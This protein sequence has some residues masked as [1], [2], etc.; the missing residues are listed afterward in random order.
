[1][2]TAPHGQAKKQAARRAPASFTYNHVVKHAVPALLAVVAACG[3]KARARDDGGAGSHDA[4]VAATR[5]AAPAPPKPA[6]VEHGVFELV[7]N[8]HAAHRAIDGE[9][10]LD[11]RDIGFARF[12]RFGLPAAHWRLGATVDGERAALADAFAPVE[13]PMSVEQARAT[14]ITVRVYGGVKRQI[15]GVKVNGRAGGKH[16]RVPLEPGW[17]T[18]A[19]PIDPGRFVA[20]ENELAFETTGGG[21]DRVAFAWIRA[22][23]SHPK[24]DEDPLAAAAFDAK[25]DALELASGAELAWYVAVPDGANLVAE[26]APGPCR[27]EVAARAS[28]ATAAGG[29]LG[30]DMRRIDLSA[31]AGRVARLSLAARDCPRARLVHPRITLVG[32]PPQPLPAADP[33]RF[34]VVWVMD[35]LRADKLPAFTAGARATTPN[36]VE[37]AKSSVVFREHYAHGTG[38]PAL[39]ASVA[40]LDRELAAAGYYTTGVTGAGKTPDEP[41]AG[42]VIVDTALAQLDK[43]RDG[44]TYLFVRT[45]DNRPP[46]VARTPWIDTYAPGGHPDARAI[47]DSDVSYADVQLGRVVQRLQSLGAWDQTLLIITSDRGLALDAGD[48]GSLR[49]SVVHVPLLVHD[50]GRF[51]GG[52]V[53]DDGTEQADLVPTILAALGRPAP[54]AEAGAPLEPVAQGIGRG[55]ARPAFTALG[56]RAFAVRVG[57]WK[58]TVGATANPVV[59]DLAADPDE[60]KDF[61]PSRTAERRMLTDQLGLALALGVRWE[62]AAWGV[63]TNVTAAGAAALDD[64]STP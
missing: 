34:V 44:R 20:G 31:L 27:V 23:T 55:W 63:T 18:L 45:L 22:G 13:L 10:V 46:L 58:L 32:P 25:A 40:T 57:R 3:S 43:H 36:L 8:R 60:T 59:S 16:A 17:Q 49:E 52:T 19:L 29:L 41:V 9:V 51:P 50:P 47:Y 7:A 11:A 33:P 54:A 28:D 39:D 42:E 21:K 12:T 53:V 26:L 1:V 15:L 24:G 4:A 37:L 6:R 61:A 35:G 62:K 64:A 30:G 2:E 14:Q 48:E 56:D 38:G 5:D